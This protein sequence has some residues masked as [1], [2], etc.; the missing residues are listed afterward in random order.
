[1]PISYQRPVARVDLICHTPFSFCGFPPRFR[2][3]EPIVCVCVYVCVCVCVC[4]WS[5]PLEQFQR[6]WCVCVC[7]RQTS[8]IHFRNTSLHLQQRAQCQRQQWPWAQTLYVHLFVYIHVCICFVMDTCRITSIPSRVAGVAM[9]TLS[10][11]SRDFL[12]VSVGQ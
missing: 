11:N 5:Q 9:M 4:G 7:A 2:I 12:C 8:A 6:I 3:C 10:T 1:M